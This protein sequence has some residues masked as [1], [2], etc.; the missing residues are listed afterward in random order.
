MSSRLRHP[1]PPG[2]A[3]DVPAE[4]VGGVLDDPE[5]KAWAGS[6]RDASAGPVRFE[7]ILH[8]HSRDSIGGE[9]REPPGCFHDLHLDQ[10][11]DAITAAW[12]P[13]DLRP[14]FYT[15]LTDLDAITYRQEVM[16]DLESDAVRGAVESF[17]EQMRAMR[18]DF[19]LATTLDYHYERQ[20]W[21]LAA[22]TAYCEA[23]ARLSEDLALLELR[24]RGLR[25][26]RDY[27][28]D[29]AGGT[30][31]RG[32]AAAIRELLANLSSFR[33]C[34]LVQNGQ[35][36]VL[37]FDGE[38]DYTAAV[39]ATFERF[40]RSAVRE[41][42]VGLPDLGRLNHVEAQILERVAWLYPVV[43][44]AL[45]AFCAQHVAYLEE[46]I[47]RFDREIQFYLAYLGFIDRL[48]RTGL[49][50]CYPLVSDSSK[51]VSARDAFDLALAATLVRAA[52]LSSAMIY[53]C[54]DRSASLSS[55]A[56]IRGERRPLLACSASCTTSDAW[57]VG[58]GHRGSSF[59]FDRLFTH[60]EQA[61]DVRSLRGK[62]EDDLLRL[63]RIL[64]QATPGSIVILNEIFAS[65]TLSDAI[66][67]GRK[68]MAEIARLDCLAVCVT[69]LDEL[70]AGDGRIVSVVGAVASDDP[71]VR[72]FKLERRPADG[73]AYAQAIAEKYRV[74]GE[75]LQPADQRMRTLL[76]HPDRDFDAGRKPGGPE[77]E[78]V[79]DLALDTLL[80]AMAGD[81]ALIS[82]VARAALL[83]GGDLDTIRYRQDILSDCLR[84]GAVVRELYQ[85]ALEATDRR[86]HP[87][88]RLI[89]RFPSGIL[90][91]AV[92]MLVMLVAML[93]K[94]RGIADLH[95]GRFASGGFT[96][97]F[98]GIQE[99][100]G[101]EYLES[102]QDHLKRLRLQE[103]RAAEC[104]AGQEERRHE[105]HR[106][107]SHRAGHRAASGGSSAVGHPGYTVRIHE[108]DEAGAR[109]LSEL[110][111]RGLN[112]VAN[113]AA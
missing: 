63:R 65:T 110:R 37:P 79:Q 52:A 22:V 39:E 14:F 105:L 54:A 23:A 30:A 77:W 57:A 104:R 44:S 50:F 103:R 56:P 60:F 9:R 26:F 6:G 16:R 99:E 46:T 3:S 82:E 67:L 69:F 102:V 15:P 12:E 11:V 40:R 10:V 88:F 59:P 25:A 90:H 62:L 107:P 55:P 89:G 24:S 28:T 1:D 111:D 74:T 38:P 64:R 21:F 73:L 81:D 41:Y 17:S 2:V 42:R 18:G 61:E 109:Y 86:R 53:S 87:Y 27:L 4:A 70:A 72:T 35:I 5:R 91:S 92:D 93:R 19:R 45:D 112:E 85:L 33:Y 13:Y 8:V 68:I 47:A 106:A 98:T 75:W 80:R 36:T 83:A 71:T 20:R 100:I 96:A 94:V 32:L 101:D 76:M 31:S 51:E 108:R 66:H 48:R 49:R 84:N 7:S 43:F 97:L 58:A 113:A 29:Y 95:A 34:L 78:L